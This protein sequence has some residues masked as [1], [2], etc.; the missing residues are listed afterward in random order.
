LGE[1]E[2]LSIDDVDAQNRAL[3]AWQDAERRAYEQSVKRG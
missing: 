3:D 2:H 1:L